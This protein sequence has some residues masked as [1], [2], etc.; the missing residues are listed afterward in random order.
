MRPLR[1]AAAQRAI[2]A[3]RT[4]T[5]A[6]LADIW[7]TVLALP[8]VCVFDN[9]FDLWG[10]S[11]LAVKVTALVAEQFGVSLPTRAIFDAENLASL[12]VR[13]DQIATQPAA[14]PAFQPIKR[15]ARQPQTPN[16]VS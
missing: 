13:I 10:Q 8:E 14:V 9:F 6:R 3:P 15:Q 12:A 5:E 2:T 7:K 11:L 1:E 16:T 4:S